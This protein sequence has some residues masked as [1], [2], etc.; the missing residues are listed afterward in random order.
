MGG[1]GTVTFSGVFHTGSDKILRHP[2]MN[3]G[4]TPNWLCIHFYQQI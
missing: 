3:T 2:N 4:F 1:G